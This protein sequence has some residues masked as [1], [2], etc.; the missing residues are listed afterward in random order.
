M[1]INENYSFCGQSVDL[2]L[3]IDES[4][5]DSCCLYVN[6]YANFNAVFDVK[7][8]IN[9]EII[10]K[11]GVVISD[12][13][14]YLSHEENILI[15]INELLLNLA[16]QVEEEDFFW[17]SIAKFL[18][19]DNEDEDEY[20]EVV[21]VK[22]YVE[23][24]EFKL[25]NDG[26]ETFFDQYNT[27]EYIK[28]IEE[29]SDMLQ[30]ISKARKKY[31]ELNNSTGMNIISQV[32]LNKLNEIIADMYIDMEDLIEVTSKVKEFNASQD[33]EYIIISRVGKIAV[34]SKYDLTLDDELDCFGDFRS[35]WNFAGVEG[36]TGYICELNLECED[37]IHI[38]KTIELLS[39]Y[40]S[41]NHVKKYL[42]DTKIKSGLIVVKKKLPQL[43]KFNGIPNGMA[44]PYYQ[45][46]VTADSSYIDELKV[47][48]PFANIDCDIKCKFIVNEKVEKEFSEKY[49]FEA[50]YDDDFSCIEN[51][52]T[53]LDYM[54]SDVYDNVSSQH[55]LILERGT[56]DEF[57]EFA[58]NPNV[59]LEIEVI[60]INVS[61]SAKDSHLWYWL[62]NLSPMD[63]KSWIESILR[64]I[65][66]IEDNYN[67]EVPS[68]EKHLY[69]SKNEYELLK[70]SKERCIKLIDNDVFL[71]DESLVDILT[72][73]PNYIMNIEFK[74][75]GNRIS[76]EYKVGD[77]EIEKF[78]D[79]IHI[80]SKAGNQI[81]CDTWDGMHAYFDTSKDFE[82]TRY[83]YGGYVLKSG[84]MK[85]QIYNPY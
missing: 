14:L 55:N 58:E 37:G 2:C 53:L 54:S 67:E 21:Q 73:N 68:I 51:F 57:C 25:I 13:Y 56:I 28:D 44:K 17:D 48:S 3:T 32:N 29:L 45:T 9:E 19:E 83:G 23:L 35:F 30:I 52:S 20:D 84:D 24:V 50:N 33:E 61:R 7:M 75:N 59:I 27:V 79:K 63:G 31:I 4:K 15:P 12:K 40:P 65:E 85:I 72:A 42:I 1:Q 36:E 5:V 70:K 22:L 82:I 8:I 71:K 11:K 64:D 74:F 39:D 69:L 81:C 10:V 6:K 46:I 34:L 66:M 16:K 38:N 18:P 62:N 78:I 80:S 77:L 26:I 41:V 76:N 49:I 60:N 47:I 43:V